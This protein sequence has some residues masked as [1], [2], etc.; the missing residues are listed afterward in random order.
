MRCWDDR[1]GAAA[2]PLRLSPTALLIGSLS[3]RAAVG[4]GSHGLVVMRVIFV[5]VYMISGE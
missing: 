1:R 5:F 2:V 4:F 3:I